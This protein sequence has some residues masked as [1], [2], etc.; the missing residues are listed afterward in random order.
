MY[1]EGKSKLTLQDNLHLQGTIQKTCLLFFFLIIQFLGARSFHIFKFYL[2]IIT[3]ITNHSGHGVRGTTAFARSN[4]G[5]VGSNPTKGI[6]C[7]SVCFVFGC[8]VK[9]AALRRID[10]PSKESYRLSI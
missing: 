1:G 7:V 9:V 3:T 5:L 6:I 8:P 2:H 10:P 4:T